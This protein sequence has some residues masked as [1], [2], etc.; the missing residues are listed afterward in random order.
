M[1]NLDALI[2]NL[3]LFFIVSFII[4]I[5][6]YIVIIIGVIVLIRYLWRKGTKD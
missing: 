3:D 2:Q 4:S 1:E 6:F 5:I